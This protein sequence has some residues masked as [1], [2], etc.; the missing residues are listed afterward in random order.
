MALLI[1]I[2]LCIAFGSFVGLVGYGVLRL[3]FGGSDAYRVGYT[4][5]MPAPQPPVV[6]PVLQMSPPEL[7]SY[8]ILRRQMLEA[9][10]R[11][12]VRK[13]EKLR[14]AGQ[15]SQSD[16]EAAINA[17]LDADLLVSADSSYKPGR[18]C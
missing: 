13:W 8:Q 3:I 6:E 11:E 4:S 17:L 18:T 1:L 7:L 9:E 12:L 2:G 5:R 16:Y 15:V 10:G 14:D